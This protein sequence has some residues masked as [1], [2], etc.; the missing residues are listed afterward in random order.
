MRVLRMILGHI[1]E[2]L[3]AHLAPLEAHLAPVGSVGAF[4]T[5]NVDFPIGKVTFFFWVSKFASLPW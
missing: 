2:N 3:E 5:K 4:G 1:Y